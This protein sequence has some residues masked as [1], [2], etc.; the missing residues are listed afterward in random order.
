MTDR[1]TTCIECGEE[2]DY[3]YIEEV[4]AEMAANSMCFLDNYWRTQ[5]TTERDR[6]FVTPNY[7]HYRIEDAEETRIRG[8]GGRTFKVHYLTGEEATTSNL[9]HQGV[10]PE[11]WRDRFPVTA[12]LEG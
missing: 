8:F 9:W 12:T 5:Q 4:S 11:H 10:I 1:P 6:A 2:I 7:N 3:V